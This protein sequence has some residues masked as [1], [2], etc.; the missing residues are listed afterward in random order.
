MTNRTAATSSAT[1]M[2]IWMA[3]AGKR[4]TMPAPN[5]APTTAAAIIV[6]ERQRIDDDGSDED[7]RL[8]D[9]GQRVTGVQRA[10]NTFVGHEFHQFE[11]GRRGRE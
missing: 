9:R 7:Q 11:D 10:G 3:R 1:P 8:G 5:Q 2:P 4:A 6:D